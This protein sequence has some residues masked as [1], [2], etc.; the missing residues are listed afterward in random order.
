M[1]YRTRRTAC[2]KVQSMRKKTLE[3]LQGFGLAGLRKLDGE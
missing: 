2:S 1:I 3:E